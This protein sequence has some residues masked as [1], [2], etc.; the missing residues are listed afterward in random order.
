MPGSGQSPGQRA[1]AAYLLAAL[2]RDGKLQESQL[3]EDDP[4]AVRIEIYEKA[5]E[6]GLTRQL[7]EN[8]ANLNPKIT[9]L[10]PED[11]R[12]ILAEAGRSSPLQWCNSPGTLTPA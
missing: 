11:L 7:N 1:P 3:K 6:W 2:H 12:S 9:G 4:L 8:G 10:D 5:L